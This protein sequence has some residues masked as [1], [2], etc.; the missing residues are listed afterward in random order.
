MTT[1]PTLSQ[2]YSGVLNDLETEYGINISLSQKV[3]LRAIAAVQAGKLWLLYK[4]IGFVQKNIWP[5]TADPEASGG[6]LERF[7]RVRLGRNPRAA[8]AGQYR[9]LVTGT[10]GAVIPAQAVFKSDD[11]ALHPGFLFILD[12]AHTLLT[13]TADTMVLRALTGGVEAKLAVGNTLTT[14][15]PIANVDSVVT[16][17]VEEI[18]PL[19]AE[20]LAAYRQAIL[21]SFRL[22]AQGGAATDYRI[23]AADAQGVAKVYPYAKEGET[24]ANNIYVEAT[25]ADST[26]GKGTPSQAILDDV[27][28]VVNFDP[29]TSIPI[30]ERG[31]RPNTVRCYFLAITPKNVDITITGFVGVT[32][33]QKALIL[34]AITNFLATV[35]PFVAAADTAASRNDIVSANNLN[36]VIFSQIP[37]AVYTG[38]TLQVAGVSL[39]S[40]TFNLGNIPNLNSITYN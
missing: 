32:V 28:D 40:Y 39:S 16:V 36:G 29:D 11:T 9:V 24:N 10:I 34:A 18:Q 1:L 26:D 8:V 33:T 13:A 3:A 15:S 37:A 27:E 14:V 12:N 19:A 20:T 17:T 7:G 4:L 6:T 5:D 25:I 30:N 2:L 38:I 31:R 35:R 23:W 21:D 22:E